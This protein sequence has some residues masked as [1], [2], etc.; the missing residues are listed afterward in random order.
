MVHAA[1]SFSCNVCC[2]GVEVTTR[3]GYTCFPCQARPS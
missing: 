3:L 1:S 2:A